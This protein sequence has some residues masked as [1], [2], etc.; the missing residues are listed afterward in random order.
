[1]KKSIRNQLNKQ[2]TIIELVEKRHQLRLAK[3]T[4]NLFCINF[5]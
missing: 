4:D 2:E 3:A 1:M 5:V